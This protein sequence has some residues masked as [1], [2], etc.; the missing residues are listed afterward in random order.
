[1]IG[2]D[3]N[4]WFSDLLGE[5]I[6]RITTA[7]VVT[8]DYSDA[9]NGVTVN[10]ALGT[11]HN[12][13]GGTDTL[14]D[15]Q[16]VIGSSAGHNTLIGGPASETLV[17]QGSHNVLD[18][19]G[20]RDTLTGGMTAGIGDDIFKFGAAALADAQSSM[21]DQVTDYSNSAGDQ[22]DLSAVLSAA[23]NHGT[24]QSISSLVHLVE[25]ASGT[26]ARLM[27]DPDG[28]ASAADFVTIAQLDGLHV[29]DPVNVTLDGSQPTGATVAVA[30]PVTPQD[31]DNSGTSDILWHNDSGQNAVEFLH[32]GQFQSE[33]T[34]PG[35]TSDWH[36]AGIGDFNGDGTSDILW[37]NDNGANSIE[38]LNNGRFE[39]AVA[40]PTKPTG[41]H[42]AGIGD[43]NG[44]GTSDILWHNDNGPNVIE[45]LHNGQFQ[46]ETTLPGT[47]SEWHVAGIGDFNGS[48]TSDILWH[49][50]NGANAIEFL[51]NGR[52]QSAAPLPGTT[53]DWHVASIGD[54]NGDGT[55]D[56]LWHND[57]GANGI[58]L[59]HNG[60]FQSGVPLPGTTSDWHVV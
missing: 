58:E 13:F 21:F 8:V 23:Y 11:A 31:F 45:F 10:L 47:T 36:I 18:G 50:D 22:I 6:G 29:G 2:P 52:F 5:N 20:G 27:I 30:R 51:H 32:N 59:L 19:G 25:D 60:Q 4:L 44:S 56:I 40:L 57:N 48:G 35:T 14:S 1:V 49:N 34:L 17:A 37:L 39:S 7:S 46:S 16:T 53:S 41:W 55:S 12:G 38:F 26:F 15:V 3:G 9:P 43:F 42:V 28:A 54:F 24:G 33:T